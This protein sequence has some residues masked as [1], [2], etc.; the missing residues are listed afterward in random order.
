M[1]IRGMKVSL[2]API[3]GYYYCKSTGP[4]LYEHF[5]PGWSR[6]EYCL[7]LELE[8]ENDLIVIVPD[9]PVSN[10]SIVEKEISEN[11]KAE[12]QKYLNEMRKELGALKMLFSF[13]SNIPKLDEVIEFDSQSRRFKIFPKIC[14]FMFGSCRRNRRLSHDKNLNFTT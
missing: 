12:F 11:I 9:K 14:I 2:K 4:D 1:V 7:G 8:N 10:M 6:F 13:G 5:S 3:D